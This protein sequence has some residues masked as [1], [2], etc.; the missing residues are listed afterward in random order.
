MVPGTLDFSCLFLPIS[1]ITVVCLSSL[2][3]A[4]ESRAVRRT[5]VCQES[6]GWV[7]EKTESRAH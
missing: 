2:G 6:T 3:E 4:L 1:R 7:T 5:W